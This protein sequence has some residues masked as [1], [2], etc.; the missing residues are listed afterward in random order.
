[1]SEQKKKKN[2]P[3]CGRS[4]RR[5]ASCRFYL[6]LWSSTCLSYGPASRVELWG[7]LLAYK[8]QRTGLLLCGER[9]RGWM[10]ECVG[11]AASSAPAPDLEHLSDASKWFLL[12]RLTT[13]QH[14]RTEKRLKVGP[15][16]ITLTH[17]HDVC[18]GKEASVAVGGLALIH[19]AVRCFGVVQHYCVT[20][21]PSVGCRRVCRD[22]RQTHSYNMGEQSLPQRV[23]Q[24]TG[25]I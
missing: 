1:M 4:K 23:T 11:S 10:M 12:Q 15:Q 7:N 13:T 24:Q 5:A 20:Q 18:I 2:L 16:I 9:A 19:G 3:K 17:Y 6:H 14:K 22:T 25:S 8:W 21:N